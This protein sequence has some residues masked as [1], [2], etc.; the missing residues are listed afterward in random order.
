MLYD[1]FI[2]NSIAKNFCNPLDPEYKRLIAWLKS[3]DP[4][5]GERNAYLVLSK[6]ILHEY[7]A[8]CA[9]SCS[10]TNIAVIVD[11]VTRQERRVL[12]T[13]DQIKEFK[14]RYFTK[15]ILK[16]LKCNAHDRDHL[17][18]VL[19]SNR[20]YALSRDPHFVYDIIHFPG[21]DGARAEMRPQDLPYDE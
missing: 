20:K 6:K 15:R 11:I 19:L 12:I 13:N 4:S 8:T 5:R 16:N 1:I 9:S 3:Y 7:Y 2:D 18:A 14:R 17:P 10:D 21:F